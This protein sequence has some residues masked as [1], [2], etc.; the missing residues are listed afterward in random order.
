[1][2]D[3]PSQL[4]A[5]NPLPSGAGFQ[6]AERQNNGETP[7]DRPAVMQDNTPLE[8]N[9]TTKL[10]TSVPPAP[11]TASTNSRGVTPSVDNESSAN[12]HHDNRDVIMSGGY[13]TRGTYRGNGATGTGAANAT[14][15]SQ[16]TGAPARIYMNEKIVPYLLEGMKMV[17]K[18]QPTNPLQVLGEYLLQKSSE[19]GET[20]GE[21][22]AA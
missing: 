19:I 3:A 22:S 4:P 14:P 6:N 15:Q 8:P 11:A 21:Q 20:A 1:M 18:D 16:A 7:Q 2:A 12:K 13:E 10:G 5:G 17:A 9:S